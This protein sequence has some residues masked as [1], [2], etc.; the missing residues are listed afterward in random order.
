MYVFGGQNLIRKS[1]PEALAVSCALD[2]ATDPV[3]VPSAVGGCEKLPF[4]GNL[5]VISMAAHVYEIELIFVLSSTAVAVSFLA[6][7]HGS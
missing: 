7:E 2:S 6:P 4:A 3:T 1:T 5:K